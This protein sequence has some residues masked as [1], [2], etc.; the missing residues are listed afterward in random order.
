MTEMNEII[1][2]VDRK[3]EALTQRDERM[4]PPRND[5]TANAAIGNIMREERQ[6][7]RRAK[8]K[9][10]TRVWRAEDEKT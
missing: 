10:N 6:K 1:H 4:H 8:N 9:Y 3:E 7:K 2:W 5:P